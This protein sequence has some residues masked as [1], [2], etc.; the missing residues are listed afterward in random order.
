MEWKANWR[1]QTSG[2][3]SMVKLILKQ[4][5]RRICFKIS[6]QGRVSKG[7]RGSSKENEGDDVTHVT[8]RGPSFLPILDFSKEMVKMAE[9]QSGC[10]TGRHPDK[11]L[12]D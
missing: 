6:Q 12:P 7:P 11:N 10:V 8:A 5:R 1:G 2:H 4:R 3:K 9:T